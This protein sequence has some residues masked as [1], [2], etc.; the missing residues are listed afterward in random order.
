MES[1]PS[2]KKMTESGNTQ[3]IK[4]NQNKRNKINSFS[5]ADMV[6]EVES[7]D[8]EVYDPNMT[9]DNL[10]ADDSAEFL[11]PT[12]AVV[13]NKGESPGKKIKNALTKTLLNLSL[14]HI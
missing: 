5:Y 4:I 6:Y 3:A 9:V 10:Q 11:S 13:E 8:E 12:N 1:T 2:K 14:I 7:D